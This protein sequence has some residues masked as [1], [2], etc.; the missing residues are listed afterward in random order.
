MYGTVSSKRLSFR[1]LT[2]GLPFIK[3]FGVTV[4]KDKPKGNIPK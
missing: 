1:Q 3:E 4:S 2:Q